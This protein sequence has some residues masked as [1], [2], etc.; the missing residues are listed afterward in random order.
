MLPQAQYFPVTAAPLKMVAGLRRHGVDC[1]QPGH[2]QRFFLRDD[3]HA[4]YHAAKR[5]VP[6][7]RH[8]LIGDDASASAARQAALGWLRQTL[9][10]EEPEL[11]ELADADPDAR[12]GFEAIARA[13]QEDLAVLASGDDDTGRTVLLDVRFPSGWR[14]ERLV[15]ASFT[16]LH[17]PVPGFVDSAAA[18]RSMVRA[19]IERGP[20]VRFVWTLCADDQLDHHPDAHQKLPWHDARALW[21]RVERQIT[22]PLPA[23]RAG[24][25]LIRTFVYPVGTLRAPERTTLLAALDAMPDEVRTYKGLPS[26]AQIEALLR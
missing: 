23:A 11:L 16:G 21:L 20:Y 18:A 5:R 4:R 3:Q 26:R 8:G 2:D 10:Q 13:V 9:A 24:L 6:R 17:A 1:G 22:V 25:F 14:P 19:M 15:G 7:D 12:N